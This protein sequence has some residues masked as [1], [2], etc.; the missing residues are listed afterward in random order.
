MSFLSKNKNVENKFFNSYTKTRTKKIMTTLQVYINKN[1]PKFI[2][3]IQEGDFDFFETT[4][5]RLEGN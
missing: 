1:L 3:E 5:K 4:I 2:S